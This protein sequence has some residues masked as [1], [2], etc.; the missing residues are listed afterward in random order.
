[1]TYMVLGEKK[2]VLPV[3]IGREL[4]QFAA[5]NVLLEQ[6]LSDP[7]RNCH[8]ERTITLR[9]ECYIGLKQPLELQERLFVEHYI[10][11]LVQSDTAFREA[12]ADCMHW[13]ARVLL[14]A[15][16]TFFLR[17]R[18]DTAVEKKRGSAVVVK[19]G[20]AENSHNL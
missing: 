14:L 18:H 3:K 20:D 11:D 17:R 19:G 4:L 9:R 7:D 16:E 6:L 2:P 8:G 1:M 5:D 13:E 10:V 15:R 12:V